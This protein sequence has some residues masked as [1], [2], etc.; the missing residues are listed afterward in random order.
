MIYDII[1][2]C[3]ELYGIEY[4]YTDITDCD[5]C[6]S[7]SDRLFTGCANCKIRKCATE[8]GI[9]NCAYCEKYACEILMELFKTDHGAKARLDLIR[10]N[11]C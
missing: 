8:K 6:I 5:G 9:K 11:F 1:C 7:G 10:S 4:R 3:K 2:M